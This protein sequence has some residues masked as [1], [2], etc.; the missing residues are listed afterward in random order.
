M[1]F[2][3]RIA[4]CNNCSE[5]R[6][7]AAHGLC[8]K[9]Y[10]ASERAAENPWA[11]ADR[12]NR[13]KVKAQRKLRTAITTILNAVDN[14]IEVMDEEHVTAIRGVCGYYLLELASGLPPAPV[15]T[16]GDV[17][18]EHDDAVNCSLP[19][20]ANSVNIE[21]QSG[22]PSSQPDDSGVV[23][24]EHEI[25]VN[26]LLPAFSEIRGAQ[27]IPVGPSSVTYLPN[28]VPIDDGTW[29]EWLK[30]MPWTTDGGSIDD[31]Y[32]TCKTI[33]YGDSVDRVPEAQ[34]PWPNSPAK[35]LKRL[36]ER[37]TGRE[38]TQ[39]TC[40]LYENGQLPIRMH[41]EQS[42][43]EAIAIFSFGAERRL[44]FCSTK[45]S[46]VDP[47]LPL[48]TLAPNSLLLFDGE[49]NRN[50][51]HGLVADEVGIG[52]HF[53]LIF[54]YFPRGNTFGVK[55]VEPDEAA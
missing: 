16:V 11:A 8:F 35:V 42:T 22:A 40:H 31:Q 9:C 34:L 36:L 54:R 25:D 5:E 53:S 51:K 14:V 6:E 17:N 15:K 21:N 52:A 23:N 26:S 50:Y 20:I 32:A 44:G 48:L 10:R 12:H 19:K 2:E 24:S 46:T 37:K 55:A 3:R 7:I 33:Q 39:C 18:S 43:S 13:A 29:E 45:D 49:F 47:N 41:H 38:F 4:T 27:V 1:S 30:S 28:F